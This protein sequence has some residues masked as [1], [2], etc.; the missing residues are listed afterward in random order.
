MHDDGLVVS[1]ETQPSQERASDAPS[2][3]K[4]NS[5]TG[6]PVLVSPFSGETGRGFLGD[7]HSR[8]L[9]E[10]S[11]GL[12]CRFQQRFHILFRVRGGDDPVQPV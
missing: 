11:A 3:Q 12:I 10:T 7:C 5:V 6:C 8:I 4:D 1:R 2:P 9:F